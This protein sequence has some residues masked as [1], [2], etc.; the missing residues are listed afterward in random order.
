MFCS[1][2]CGTKAGREGVGV[3]VGMRIGDG[4]RQR[5]GTRGLPY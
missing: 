3:G 1:L 2:D 5:D 4:E